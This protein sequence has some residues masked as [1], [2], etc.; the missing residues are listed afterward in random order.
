MRGCLVGVSLLALAACTGSDA[1]ARP[2]PPPGTTLA[3]LPG[4][5]QRIA[6]GRPAPSTD[7]V[8]VWVC[9]VPLDTVD[10]IYGGLTLRLPLTADE[11]VERTDDRLHAY[12][13]SISHGAYSLRL[14]AGGTVE[15]SPTDTAE[16]CTS[17]AL[18]ASSEEADAV[19]AVANAEHAATA[20]GGWGRPGSWPTCT[21]QCSARTTRRVAYVGASDFHPDWGPVPALDLLE[22]E[23]GHTL[24]L[25]HS[26]D[27]ADGESGHTSALDV[28]SNSA[29]PRE[30]EIGRAHV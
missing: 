24:D 5:A 27:V 4:V 6:T 29:A 13:A 15:M 11:I 3:A 21:E 25:P 28:M 9:D 7:T 20:P 23:I 26:G 1:S 17:R 12:F 8:E 14:V 19:L 2:D 30:V 18:D 16:Q 22:H 10:P